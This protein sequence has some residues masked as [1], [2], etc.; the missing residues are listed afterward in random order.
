MTGYGQGQQDAGDL[1]VTVELKTVNNRFADVRFRLPTELAA[2][3]SRVRRRVLSHVRRGRAEL[4]VRVERG[5]VAQNM[6]VLHRDC[7][8]SVLAAA[9]QLR[10]EY[11]VEGDLDLGRLLSVPGLFRSEGPVLEG[12]AGQLEALDICLASALDALDADRAREG[13]TL[14]GELVERLGRMQD[15]AGKMTEQAAAMPATVR[16]RLVARLEA[17]GGDVALDPA[18][19]AQEAALL[20]ERCDVT[21]ELVRLDGHLTQA[22]SL[23]E[24]PD[25]DPVGKRLDFLLQE[26]H[27]ETNTVSSKSSDLEL[28]RSALA[29]KSEGEKVREQ[30]QNLE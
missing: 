6:P 18:R 22:R 1:R 16:D 19:V 21:E 15:L 3:E 25:G 23:I 2:W 27:R 7:V 11:G 5:G 30:V 13:R 17:L 8:E 14:A 29:M 20:A 26:I 12:D 4:S 9:R 28:T 10:E 24:Q